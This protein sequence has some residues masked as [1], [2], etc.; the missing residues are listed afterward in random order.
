[1]TVTERARQVQDAFQRGRSEVLSTA[2]A[3]LEPSD[4][5]ALIAAAPALHRLADLL[6]T[7]PHQV[8]TGTE[9]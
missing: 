7:G 8:P 3:E 2:W 6:H 4:R 1:L 5:T 9:P